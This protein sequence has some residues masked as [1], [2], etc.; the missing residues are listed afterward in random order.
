[1]LSYSQRSKEENKRED[2]VCLIKERSN[3]LKIPANFS[4][5]FLAALGLDIAI[6]K[7]ITMD[8]VT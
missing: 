6:L 5:V 1:M 2:L 8:K 3:F 4:Y 7:P